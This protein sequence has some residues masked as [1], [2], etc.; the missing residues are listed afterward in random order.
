M[1]Y[2]GNQGADKNGTYAPGKLGAWAICRFQCKGDWSAAS[3]LYRL[4][5]RWKQ[6]KKLQRFGHEWIAETSQ[7]W[8]DGAGLSIYE[9][10]DRALPRLRKLPF[11]QIRQMR[12]G[13]SN[14]KLLWM[15]LKQEELPQ[16]LELDFQIYM[17]KMHGGKIIGGEP[18]PKET[19]Y[20]KKLKLAKVS[21]INLAKYKLSF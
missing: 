6:S 20:L 17:S 5:W 15:R 4:Q 21:K 7:Q 13:T 2:N 16:T 12:L 3:L 11:V 19:K 10:R 9:F 1:T 14:R 8:A 18:A